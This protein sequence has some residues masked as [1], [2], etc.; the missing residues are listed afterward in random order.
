MFDPYVTAVQK[1]E[2]DDY[3]PLYFVTKSMDDAMAKLRKYAQDWDR[4]FINVYDPYTQTVS[5]MSHEEYA[6]V[7]VKTVKEDTNRL[8][9]TLQNCKIQKCEAPVRDRCRG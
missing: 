9:E 7:N 3:Q 8:A 6:K 1:Y 2:D 4:P 5:Q